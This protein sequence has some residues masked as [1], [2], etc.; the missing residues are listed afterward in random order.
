MDDVISTFQRGFKPI[1]QEVES[2]PCIARGKAVH[3]S[4]SLGDDGSKKPSTNTGLNVRNGLVQRRASSQNLNPDVENPGARAMRIPSFASQNSLAPSPTPSP[5]RLTPTSSYASSASGGYFQQAAIAKKKP[6]PP[7]PKRIGSSNSLF[8]V[9]LYSFDGQSQG[10][11][12][13]REGD[14]IKV[15]K[16]TDSTDDWWEGELNGVKGSFPANYCKLS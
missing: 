13:F 5:G 4:M 7:P 15:V 1:Q 12:S 9:A 8:A 3:Q 10:D 14:R 6:P 11:L 16:K 2:I